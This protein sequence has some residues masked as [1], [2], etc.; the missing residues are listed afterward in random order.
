MS[1]FILALGAPLVSQHQAVSGAKEVTKS[2]LASKVVREEEWAERNKWAASYSV[3]FNTHKCLGCWIIL[4]CFAN[5]KKGLAR[6]SHLS[7]VMYLIHEGQDALTPKPVHGH[8]FYKKNT[9]QLKKPAGAC[10]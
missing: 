8:P 7:K 1:S 3:A 9:E 6:Q 10:Q 2:A 4:F 5:E